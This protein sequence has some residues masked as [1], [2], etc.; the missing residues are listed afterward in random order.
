SQSPARPGW[1]DQRQAKEGRDGVQDVAQALVPHPPAKAHAPRHDAQS[2]RAAE[3]EK[4]RDTLHR[5]CSLLWDLVAIAP[6]QQ[7]SHL[8]QLRHPARLDPLDDEDVALVVEAGIVR[9]DELAGRARFRL[10][11]RLEAGQRLL[12]PLGVVAEVDDRLV[13]PV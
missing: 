1:L 2:D 4:E 7:P 5:W 13:V 11:P 8:L 12:A 3:S 6:R 10:L 9:V